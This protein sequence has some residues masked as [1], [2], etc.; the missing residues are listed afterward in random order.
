VYVHVPPCRYDALDAASQFVSDGFDCIV[1]I[2]SDTLR[3]FTI[4]KLGQLFN[5]QV[6][7]APSHVCMPSLTALLCMPRISSE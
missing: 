5:Q 4:E 3:I 2:A 1:A 7:L 6:C